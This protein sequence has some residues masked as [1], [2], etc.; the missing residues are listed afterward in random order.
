MRCAWKELLSILPHWVSAEADRS[1]R[2]TLQEIRLRCGQSVEYV[3]ANSVRYSSRSVCK[4]DLLFCI[5]TASR[6]SPWAA[7]TM[8]HGFLTGPGGHRIGVCGEAVS[9]G[10]HMQGI[11]NPISLCIRV[12]RDFPGIAEK[13]LE[14]LKNP[15]FSLAFFGICEY[16]SFINNLL[17]GNGETII[18]N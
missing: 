13:V 9:Q 2:D 15:I 3:C 10:S 11:R 12:A 17:S 7:G 14:N 18:I 6:Y 1:Y 8:S 16:T 5:N 4:E